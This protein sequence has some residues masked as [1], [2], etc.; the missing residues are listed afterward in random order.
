LLLKKLLLGNE[1]I[2]LGAI[3]AGLSVAT[4]YPGTPSTEIL[5][6]IAKEAVRTDGKAAGIYVEWS[7]N[8]KSAL[9]VAAGAALSGVR[10]LVAMNQAGVNIAS[11]PFMNLNYMKITG[12]LVIVAADDPGPHFSQTEQDSRH[13]ARYAKLAVF[14]PSSVEEAYLMVADAFD[15]SEKYGHPVILRPTT[16]VCHSCASVDLAALPS[17]SPKARRGFDKTM[18]H[19]NIFSSQ[20]RKDHEDIEAALLKM[21]AD[22]SA[23][24]GNSLIVTP[25]VLGSPNDDS[26]PSGNGILGIAAG[27]VS[28]AYAMEIL[29]PIPPGLKLLKVG[30]FPF[31]VDLALDFLGGLDEVLVLEELDPVIEDEL[32][33]L[34][35]NRHLRAE[36][37]G[38][39]SGDMPKAGEYSPMLA[40]EKID[41]FLKRKVWVHISDLE[42]EK[43]L[44]SAPEPP[45]L[46]ASPASV[47]P[48]TLAAAAAAADV[49]IQPLPEPPPL[50]PRLPVLCADCPHRLSFRA[51]NEAVRKHGRDRK[52]VFSGDLGCY[53]LGNAPPLEMMDTCLCMGAGIT[54]AQGIGRVE[55]GAL[56]FAFI[57]DSTFF[58]TGLA[59]L[60]NAVYNGSDIIIVVLDNGTSAITGNQP[61]PGVGINAMG[62][63]TAKISIPALAAALGI[64]EIVRS[65]PNDPKTSEA[66]IA[67]VID[68]KGVRLVI[69]EGP[70][71]VHA[72]NGNK[73]PGELNSGGGPL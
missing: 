47:A 56:S 12:G 4:G 29:T 35:G 67:Q 2:A 55:P 57:G 65:D 13:F 6:T 31:P 19:W 43:L 15:Y 33:K 68:K 3:R 40:A 9:E 64:K 39:R 62:I 48:A 14:D 25:N 20:A 26:L 16:G 58:H 32:V 51:V 30:T 23:Y 22:F 53:T 54:M 10:A 52:A 34:C 63:A 7:V 1:A 46:P 36:I 28:Y 61:H 66:A 5:E 70:C 71:V 18:T 59:G 37:R 24:R 72:P 69:F 49:Q 8:E 21:G 42:K 17:G 60:V 41:A 44:E 45:P 27:G 38:K 11:D 73:V 50:P